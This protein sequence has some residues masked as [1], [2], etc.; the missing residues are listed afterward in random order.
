MGGIVATPPVGSYDF[1]VIQA[2]AAWDAFTRA[3][4]VQPPPGS[5]QSNRQVGE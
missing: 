4:I 1:W 5:D 2:F 3:A